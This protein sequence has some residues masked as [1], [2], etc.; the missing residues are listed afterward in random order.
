M[1]EM[2]F[3]CQKEQ[4]PCLISIPLMKYFKILPTRVV[5]HLE[6]IVR[7]GLLLLI[8]MHT[9]Y[10]IPNQMVLILTYKCIFPTLVDIVIASA[11]KMPTFL[12]C[13]NPKTLVW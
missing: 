7:V 3:F 13:D 9:T 2:L 4:Q 12:I 5:I 8:I 11:V 10:P 1:K 6:T